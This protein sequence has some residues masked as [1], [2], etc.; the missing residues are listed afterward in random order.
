MPTRSAAPWKSMTLGCVRS[1]SGGLEP[2]EAVW[3]GSLQSSFAKPVLAELGSISAKERGW[4]RRMWERFSKRGLLGKV[5]CYFL[6]VRIHPI[7]VCAILTV[8]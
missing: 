4:V 5:S 8:L 2:W 6:T 7:R 1:G 3:R